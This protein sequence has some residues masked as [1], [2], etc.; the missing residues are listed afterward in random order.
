MISKKTILIAGGGPAGLMAAWKLSQHFRVLLFEKEKTS[1]RKFLLAGNGG[2]NITNSAE[3]NELY[4]KY[5]P[6]GF[7]DEALTIF[8]PQQLREWLSDMGISTYTGSS[9]RVFSVKELKASDVLKK[10]TTSMLSRGVEFFP[11]HKL[12]AFDREMKFLFDAPDGNREV[13]ADYAVFAFGGAS[14]P[15]TGSDGKWTDM[16]NACGIETV[17]FQSSNC[18][19][20]VDW[21][22]QLLEFHEGK[23]LKNI[24]LSINGKAVRGEV[25]ITA[26]GLEGNAVYPLIPAIRNSLTEGESPVLTIDFKP[27]NLP[28]QLMKRLGN[29]KPGSTSYLR[30]LGIS[31]QALALVKACTSKVEFIDPHQF[32]DKLKG[33]PVKVKALRPLEEA[34]SSIGGL[35]LSEVSQD[36]SLKKFPRIFAAG[37]MLDWDAPTGGFLLQACFSMGYFVGTAIMEREG[38]A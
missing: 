21:A 24:E 34:I 9:G 19:V 25:L 3:G 37:E 4:S 33:F 1:G 11:N 18:G 30:C 20:E 32:I 35:A 31:P 7:L 29:A 14:W 12:V 8:G 15:V 38:M 13:K 5:S 36:F 27:F 28:E 26:Y 16:F 6:S 2:L 10:I 22:P 17:K 23:P